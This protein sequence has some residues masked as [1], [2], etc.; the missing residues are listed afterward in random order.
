MD[1]FLVVVNLLYCILKIIMASNRSRTVADNS[2]TL[3]DSL[4]PQHYKHH[5]GSLEAFQYIIT[6]CIWKS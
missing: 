3:Y 2:P 5:L 1:L 4:S 6:V